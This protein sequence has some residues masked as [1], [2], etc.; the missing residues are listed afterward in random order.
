MKIRRG[1][2]AKRRAR[3]RRP[4]QVHFTLGLTVDGKYKGTR[5]E[6][7]AQRGLD[8]LYISCLRPLLA[9]MPALPIEDLCSVQPMNADRKYV[10]LL[11]NE[12]AFFD[13]DTHDTQA[14]S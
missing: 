5:A 3:G 10:T 9:K 13:K 7:K 2:R 4:E 14:E 1:K 11:R 12:A 6:R 8:R